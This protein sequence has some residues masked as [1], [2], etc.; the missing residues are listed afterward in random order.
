M[1]GR[2]WLPACILAL[3]ALSAPAAHAAEAYPANPVRLVVPWPPGGVVG[4]AVGPGGPEEVRAAALADQ[5]R[6]EKVVKAAGIAA[7]D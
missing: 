4:I 7:R 1:H 6:M 3:S 5:G 2:R